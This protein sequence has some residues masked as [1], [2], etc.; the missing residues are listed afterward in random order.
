MT[1]Y[2]CQETCYW[3]VSWSRLVSAQSHHNLFKVHWNIILPCTSSSSVWLFLHIFW[4]QQCSKSCTLW[5]PGG[6]EVHL[7]SLLV[8]TVDDGEWLPSR[9]SPLFSG[10]QLPIPT[11]ESRGRFRFFFSE[12][13]VSCSYRESNIDFRTALRCLVTMLTELQP[14]ASVFSVCY[15]GSCQLLRP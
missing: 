1:H 6:V 11:G 14:A 4:V 7:H 3:T 12:D 9:P 10:K 15:A 5:R 8:S 2:R 13:E